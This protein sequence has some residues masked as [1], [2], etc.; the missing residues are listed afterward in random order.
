LYIAA[1]HFVAFGTSRHFTAM[2]HFGRFLGEA[3]M[4]R[5]AKPAESVEN[6]PKRTSTVVTDIIFRT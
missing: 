5:Q 3:D 2:H 4:H 6:D 1:V